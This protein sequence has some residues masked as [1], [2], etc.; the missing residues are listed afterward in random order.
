V[1]ARAGLL[2]KASNTCM[3]VIKNPIANAFF[4][5][6]ATKNTCRGKKAQADCVLQ[7]FKS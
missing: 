1:F 2:A 4:F 5:Q 6:P 3:H 7:F